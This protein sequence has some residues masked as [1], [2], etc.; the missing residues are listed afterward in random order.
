MKRWKKVL[1][2]LLAVLAAAGAAVCI[3][4]RNNIKAAYAFVTTDSQTIRENIEQKREEHRQA[5]EEVVPSISVFPPTTKQSDELLNGSTTPDQVKEELGITTQ[6]ETVGSEET[7]EDL[8]ANCVAELYA[9]KVDLMDRLRA[10][11]QEAVD[12]WL[13]LPEEEQTETMLKEI[14]L[15]GLLACYSLE[16]ETDMQVQEILQRYRAALTE[17]GGD[18]AILDELWDY[19]EDE[20]AAE[21]AY[22]MDKY[23][24]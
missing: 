7:A 21:K 20:K 6:L 22:Y 9:C 15:A 8:I 4:N 1:L 11:K 10:M 18:T 16:D 5:V 14:G 13:A 17:I 2:A 19:Y 24:R 23:L 3:Q 12:Q